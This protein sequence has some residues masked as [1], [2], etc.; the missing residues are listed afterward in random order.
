ML[1]SKNANSAFEVKGIK[2]KCVE[3]NVEVPQMEVVL[4]DDVIK[5][6]KIVKKANSEKL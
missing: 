1:K 4:V 5:K 6:K 3:E 2:W